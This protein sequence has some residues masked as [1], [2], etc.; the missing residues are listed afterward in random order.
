MKVIRE[1]AE[2]YFVLLNAGEKWYE[3]GKEFDFILESGNKISV[4]VTPLNKEEKRIA[5]IA[6]SGLPMRPKRTTRIRMQISMK[7]EATV[8]FRFKDMGFGEFYKSS[9]IEWVEE[10]DLS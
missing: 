7:N 5:E 10:M 4:L 3:A 8:V 9:G 2:S 6:L 1:G